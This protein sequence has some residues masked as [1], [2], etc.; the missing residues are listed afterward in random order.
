MSECWGRSPRDWLT[1]SEFQKP[2]SLPVK[3]WSSNIKAFFP[4]NMQIVAEETMLEDFAGFW[5]WNDSVRF[6]FWEHTVRPG[7]R[8][9]AERC[10]GDARSGTTAG[11]EGC[12][13][14][15]ESTSPVG[16]RPEGRQFYRTD[17]VPSWGTCRK[18]SLTRLPGVAHLSWLSM[19]LIL[20][21]QVEWMVGA[22]LQLPAKQKYWE[23]LY[24]NLWWKVPLKYLFVSKISAIWQKRKK[25]LSDEPLLWANKPLKQF[26]RVN[27]T[28]KTHSFWNVH[29]MWPF[30]TP[31][32]PLI[33]TV[34]Q[35]IRLH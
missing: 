30:C 29:W 32:T 23:W 1:K 20:H 28:R 8:C 2:E 16:C 27:S 18:T 15:Q 25:L 34:I 33:T 4:L 7:E 5:W 3:F 9:V 22:T 26:M 35:E 24:G 11:T 21:L 6:F 19:N 12:Y 13:R 14:W 10:P 17:P 31:L